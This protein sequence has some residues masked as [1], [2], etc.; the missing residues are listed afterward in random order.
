[1]AGDDAH[2]PREPAQFVPRA[3]EAGSAAQK[4]TLH[5]TE[6]DSSA[7]QQKR[8][9]W[10]EQITELDPSRFVFVD[11][12]GVTRSMTR[13]YGRAPKGERVPGAVPWGHGEVTTLMGALALDGVRASF[14]VDAATEADVLEVFVQQIWRPALGPGDIVIWDHL[15]AHKNPEWKA[16]LASA[17]AQLLPLPPDSPHFNPIEQCWS[18]GKEFLRATEARTVEALQQAIVKALATVTATDA[19]G[20][21]QH[22]GYRLT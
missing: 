3:N 2:P 1:L 10:R 9:I 17:Q 5:A 20:W 19:H 11:E 4:K 13:R 12:S 22:G 21:F 6:R 18:K 16:I 8:E 7:N 15:P 14:S